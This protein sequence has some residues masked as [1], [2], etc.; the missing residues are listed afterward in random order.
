MRGTRRICAMRLTIQI[1][2]IFSILRRNISFDMWRLGI[3][4]WSRRG[5]FLVYV[6]FVSIYFVNDFVKIQI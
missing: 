6:R 4:E 5:S 2:S 1:R 3:F